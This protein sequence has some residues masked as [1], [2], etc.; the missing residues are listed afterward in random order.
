LALNW[1]VLHSHPHKEELLWQQALAHDI[2]V[3]YPRIPA[4]PVNPR[5]R[6]IKAYFPGYM[7]VRVDLVAS[8]LSTF[9]YMPYATGLVTFGSEPATVSDSFI[10]VLRQ[11]VEKITAS[12][13]EIFRDLNKGDA[14]VI[15]SGPFNQY[16]AIFDYRIPGTERVRILL[17]MLN[18]RLVPIEINVNQIDKDSKK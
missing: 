6:K 10:V 7:F 4:H 9:Q 1:Y 5:A 16:K 12:G 8:G 11:Q 3:F 14:V 17:K 18:E 15:Q 2:E 13:G